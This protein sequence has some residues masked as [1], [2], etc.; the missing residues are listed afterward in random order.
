MSVYSEEILQVLNNFVV[1][2][3]TKQAMVDC[4]S[5]LTTSIGAENFI[6]HNFLPV[7]KETNSI[8]NFADNRWIQRYRECNYKLIDPRI[9][10]ATRNS[11]PVAWKDLPLENGA[12]RDQQ[13]EMM[14]EAAEYGFSDGYTFPVHGP[15]SEVA[16]LSI[17][18]STGM[19]PRYSTIDLSLISAFGHQLHKKFKAIRLASAKVD[20]HR[21]VLTQR[22]SEC[23]RWAIGGKTTWEIS[24]IVGCT[25]AT[26][27]FHIRNVLTK[28]DA[29][30]RTQAAAR[31]VGEAII[32]PSESWM[33]VPAN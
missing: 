14:K 20:P 26:V 16:A 7:L 5:K 23:I 28:L 2:P 29:S 9:S 32:S 10:Y 27:I 24:R 33:V 30:N 17:S 11:E 19:L 25:E 1:L 8:H 3:D 31:I 6:Y 12:K 13:V 22:E 18:T 21:K 15:G 4:C